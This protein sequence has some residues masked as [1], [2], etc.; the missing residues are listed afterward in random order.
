MDETKKILNLNKELTRVDSKKNPYGD[1]FA[2]ERISKA[3]D[4]FFNNIEL[5]NR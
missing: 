2:S 1:G 5:I 3:I 4:S